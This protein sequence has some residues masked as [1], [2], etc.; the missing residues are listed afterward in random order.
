MR[1]VIV[2]DLRS[3]TSHVKETCCIGMQTTLVDVRNL[4]GDV[5]EILKD[6]IALR[7]CNRRERER[8]RER[9]RELAA[10]GCVQKDAPYLNA[11]G[12]SFCNI[13]SQSPRES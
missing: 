3:V 5:R 9:E 7:I 6:S 1:S 13:L 8:N 11:I 2:F 4:I 10:K 12:C